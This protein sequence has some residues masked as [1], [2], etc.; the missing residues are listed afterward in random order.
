MKKFIPLL[1][2]IFLLSCPTTAFLACSGCSGCAGVTSEI[3]EEIKAIFGQG[4]NLIAL[5]EPQKPTPGT[6][7]QQAAQALVVPNMKTALET[8]DQGIAGIPTVY[9]KI[10]IVEG[11]I[12]KIAKTMNEWRPLKISEQQEKIATSIKK[13]IEP[14]EQ[15]LNLIQTF[16]FVIR[17]LMTGSLL[18]LAQDREW[19]NHIETLDDSLVWKAFTANTD[20][21]DK[22]DV[23]TFLT[24]NVKTT[25][26]LKNVL[27][28]LITLFEDLLA[29]LSD[30]TVVKGFE[31]ESKLR[32][33]I[34]AQAQKTAQKIQ[35]T[36]APAA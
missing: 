36:A 10:K 9:V 25:D 18:I 31:A 14:L 1:T 17:P 4:K 6:A 26:D 2:I 20:G 33:Q 13:I 8:I 23:V 15:F 28:E 3:F 35:T 21:Q 27:K 19:L 5:A 30:K 24:E 7:A 29:S 12:I 34:A 16:S 32:A 22:K 11:H